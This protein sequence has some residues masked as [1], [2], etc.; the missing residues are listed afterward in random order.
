MY[1]KNIF[2]ILPILIS[3]TRG[4]LSLEK[5]DKLLNGFIDIYDNLPNQVYTCEEGFLQN[6]EDL[7]DKYYRIEVTLLISDT[8]NL[9]SR[10]YIKCTA[11]M[12]ELQDESV[13]VANDEYHCHDV[14]QKPVLEQPLLNEEEITVDRDIPVDGIQDRDPNDP[15]FQS[16]AEASMQKYLQAIGSVEPHKVFGV[17]KASFH[18]GSALRTRVEF[19]SSPSD[20]KSGDVITAVIRRIGNNRG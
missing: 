17:V 14:E 15:I 7:D 10:K 5:K 6:V 3:L 12:Q 16:L 1:T 2:L 13:K 4:E 9:D 11:R 19:V 20:G 8:R 18:A